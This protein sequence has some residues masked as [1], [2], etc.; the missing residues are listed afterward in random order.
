[1]SEF[2]VRNTH[3]GKYL[4]GHGM[5]VERGDGARFPTHAEANELLDRQKVAGIAEIEEQKG[6]VPIAP[7]PNPWGVTKGVELPEQE[8]ATP[9][10]PAAPVFKI[11]DIVTLKSGG[12][13][14]TVAGFASDDPNRV[15]VLHSAPTMGGLF[16][17]LPGP[18]TIDQRAFHKDMLK[19]AE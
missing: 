3:T 18:P 6:G 16:G 12:L 4:T 1:M 5:W 15:I 14:M 9:A 10:E 2:M 11:G 19:H 13:R 17:T 8:P 7:Q